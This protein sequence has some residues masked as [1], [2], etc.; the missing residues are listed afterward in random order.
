MAAGPTLALALVF[1]V[2]VPSAHADWEVRRRSGTRLA[3]QAAH[4]LASRPE[5]GALAARL[6]RQVSGPSAAIWL[7]WFEDR[8]ARAP[9]DYRARLA[10][11]QVLLAA[12]RWSD[13]AAAFAAA[14]ALVPE[15]SVP[16]R[17]RALA[18]AGGG[19]ASGAAAELR[20]AL[21]LAKGATEVRLIA[22]ELV[23]RAVAAGDQDAEIEGRRAWL[24]AAP[25]DEALLLEL[26]EALGRSGRN[27]D[28]ARTLAEAPP[29]RGPARARRALAEGRHRSA[30]DDLSGAAQALEQAARLAGPEDG[31]LRREIWDRSVEIARRRD[32]LPQLAATL[33]SPRDA[34]EWAALAR[35]RDE[36]GDLNG[37]A[38]A[39][40]RALGLRPRDLEIGR[41]RIALA[42]RRSGAA[43][44]ARLYEQLAEMA[45]ADPHVVGE[46]LE[47]LQHLG[48]RTAAARV[49]D[50][51][52]ATARS[53]PE[54]LRTLALAASQWGD[55]RRT[56]TA[57]KAVLRL[58]PRDELAIVALGEVELLRGQ[59][60]GAIEAWRVLLRNHAPAEG[61]ARFAE[62]LADHD[63]AREAAAEA[64]QA[65]RHAPAEI[66][67]RR[68]LATILERQPAEL[69]AAES[70]W[71]LV[72]RLCRS[73]PRPAE[74]REARAHL[75]ALWSRRGPVR[76]EVKLRELEERIRKD[77]L[78]REALAFLVEAQLR[79]GRVDA[80][81]GTLRRWLAGV[82][83]GKAVLKV[84][85]GDAE[86]VMLLV[87]ALRQ[88]HRADDAVPWLEELAR[89]WP[90]RARDVHLQLA[91]I[92]LATHGDARAAEHATAAASASPDD[93]QV[94]LRVAAVEE[95]LGQLDRA[96]QHARHAHAARGDPSAA[97]ALASLLSRR[98]EIDEQRTLLREVLRR[99]DDD[100][101]I[102]EAGRRAIALE[103]A[104]GTLE[105]L[106]RLVADLPAGPGEGG[107]AQQR[108]LLAILER[109]LPA[110]YRDKE[111]DPEAL[112]RH[113]RLAQHALR[114][115]LELISLPDALPSVS[116]VELLGMLG[117]AEAVP[118]L[119]R[120]LAPDPG[121]GDEQQNAVGGG[122]RAARP[123]DELVAATVMALARLGGE[124]GQIAVRP[125]AE[126][127]D[128][129]VRLAAI[130]AL[131]KLGGA[132]S[133]RLAENDM[134]G[135]RVDAA[136]IGCLT[137]G[138]RGG[139][140]AAAALLTVARDA[141]R[142]MA[143]R[144]AAILGLALGQHRQEAGAL[145]AFIDGGDR[146]LAFSAAVSLG[147]LAASDASL[148]GTLV[149][150]LLE[151]TL[152]G[153][154]GGSVSAQA[155]R[156]ALT[157]VLGA[158]PLPDDATAIRGARIDADAL[159]ATLESAASDSERPPWWPGQRERISAVLLAGLNGD[160]DRA[161][162]AL[163]G[164]DA[165]ADGLG[166]GAL[167]EPPSADRATSATESAALAWVTDAVLPAVRSLA[168]AA[169][170][171]TRA[172]ALSVLSKTDAG[173]AVSTTDLVA[174]SGGDARSADAATHVAP[175]GRHRAR[176]D[177]ATIP[178]LLA[179]ARRSLDAASWRAR[180]AAVQLLA[181]LPRDR[182]VEETLLAAAADPAA[183]VRFEATAALTRS[184]SATIRRR[185]LDLAANDPS[186]AVRRAAGGQPRSSVSGP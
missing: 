71:E 67:H 113:R 148:E 96:I 12:R 76:L 164:L 65:I 159:L 138:R 146:E 125:L 40:D 17:G 115:L 108:V 127:R 90:E 52:I 109:M 45:P 29:G 36:R 126:A 165:R 9:G 77:P 38:E 95:R 68:L 97:L 176:M 182:H 14:T 31:D 112:A 69:A 26:A 25:G 47:E 116:T 105:Q 78:D 83:G 137:A 152:M 107:G 16:R 56:T 161:R 87:R 124:E 155:A 184:D 6:L 122:R 177:R 1:L 186:A 180:L 135:E 121:P 156:L 20:A 32:K 43:E 55:D 143:V 75:I 37:A 166:L 27:L 91:D 162:A 151:R 73:P 8:A 49:F 86:L 59:K 150:A 174:G 119:A 80:A 28:A 163:R 128:R 44:V 88:S 15:A 106:E 92:A 93:P 178:A 114:P 64:R 149:P 60:R 179:T 13:A 98:G 169:D 79:S 70:E 4:A 117:R 58:D 129:S 66:R 139:P 171:E 94:L 183:L 101:V 136:V 23:A 181:T 120:I 145:L 173:R 74:H 130:W 157:R 118:A 2:A 175:P 39:L 123:S 18:L 48:R 84:D 41:R 5:D 89:R 170:P 54:M 35:I 34:I 72:L 63:L 22:R 100:E 104:T 147:A 131:G 110:A 24:K 132:D 142:P 46:V 167:L 81:A 21:P 57:W 158:L 42:R 33:S 134:Q 51:V 140:Q 144:R 185:L 30:S 99:S 133:A 61:H 19:D 160:R 50:K 11:A 103:E 141:G 82:D 111:H 153:E 172:L 168:A 62:V 85:A 102:A 10:H 154:A 53:R 3:E 7:K